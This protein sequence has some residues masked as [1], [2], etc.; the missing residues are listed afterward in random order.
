M[1]E[2]AGRRRGGCKLGRGHCEMRHDE[3]AL[4]HISMSFFRSCDIVFRLATV[5][6][7]LILSDKFKT[8]LA[9]I[10]PR[11]CLLLVG[12]QHGVS[13][14]SLLQQKRL[15]RSISL[16]KRKS[17]SETCIRRQNETLTQ[18]ITTIESKF[19]RYEGQNNGV[20]VCTAGFRVHT[21]GCHGHDAV[22]M[23]AEDHAAFDRHT[24]ALTR[25]PSLGPACSV[26]K[27]NA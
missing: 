4:S 1:V 9:A 14:A 11:C 24:P 27:R 17:R 5:H 26:C 16:Q 25:S 13:V 12:S 19:L 7:L 8:E 3:K 15:C 2:A 18:N 22:Q 6:L 10:L 23:Q 21:R 20:V